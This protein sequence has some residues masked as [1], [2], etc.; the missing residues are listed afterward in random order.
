M[1]SIRINFFESVVIFVISNIVGVLLY[2]FLISFLGKESKVLYLFI[3][4]IFL[5]FVCIFWLFRDEKN[6]RIILMQ[7]LNKIGFYE[8]KLSFKYFLFVV[9]T[10]VL[11]LFIIFFFDEVF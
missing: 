1:N 4:N 6:K 8:L 7:I 5:L 9:L 10:S 2:F 3:Q 11:I